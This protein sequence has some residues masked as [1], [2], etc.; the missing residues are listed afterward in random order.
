MRKIF[1]LLIS[2]FS[3]IVTGCSEVQ[4]AEGTNKGKTDQ[5]A[6]EVNA[7]A[8]KVKLTSYKYFIQESENMNGISDVKGIIEGKINSNEEVTFP[9]HISSNQNGEKVVVVWTNTIKNLGLM[10]VYR[11][12]KLIHAVTI[13]NTIESVTVRNDILKDN[14]F[15]ETQYYH[16]SGS[17]KI[18]GAQ[19]LKLSENDAKVSWQQSIIQAGGPPEKYNV[20]VKP[21][22]VITSL[23]NKDM[24]KPIIKSYIKKTG[25]YQ[26]YEWDKQKEKFS[27]KKESDHNN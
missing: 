13:G 16:G 26:I 21:Y 3:I 1:I 22:I 18:K 27:S 12:K 19:F 9:N 2:L 4:D 20:V 17:T 7:S 15:L 23:Y 11:D 24:E 6:V 8:D 5:E 10:G 14:L 25:E